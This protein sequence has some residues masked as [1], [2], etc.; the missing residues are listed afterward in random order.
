MSSKQHLP[1]RP[2]T[3]EQINAQW[4]VVDAAGKTLGRL[5]SQVAM[6]LRGKNKA[7][8]TPYLDT[9][10]F[11]VV[12]NAEKVVLTGKKETEK[13]YWRHTEFPG[14]ERATA[15][16]KMRAQHPERMVEIAV[17]GML[18]KTRMGRHQFTKLKVYKGA[19]HPHKAQQPKPL[20][21]Q[22]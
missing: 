9:G 2:A 1:T 5:A 12:V 11:V 22:D 3:P 8:F 17:K 7:A 15:A 19:D 13:I 16:D 10:D 18:P 21:I 4:F 14:G 6:V 20:A